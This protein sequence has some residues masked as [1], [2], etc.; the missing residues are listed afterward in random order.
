MN[1]QSWHRLVVRLRVGSMQVSSA[2]ILHHRQQGGERDVCR[3]TEIQL[4]CITDWLPL[5]TSWTVWK[6]PFLYSP[7]IKEQE[8]FYAAG[9]RELKWKT[10]EA[11]ELCLEW[12]SPRHPACL[13]CAWVFPDSI[14][15]Q[16][17]THQQTEARTEGPW[18]DDTGKKRRRQESEAQH[19]RKGLV[20]ASSCGSSDGLSTNP[21]R[22]V[23]RC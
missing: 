22:K 6:L 10:C 23:K 17:V 2:G 13:R 11:A 4:Y 19:E 5:S 14:V 1:D 3:N 20:S 21:P 12:G 15:V 18:E 16:N 8:S 9:Q 7:G